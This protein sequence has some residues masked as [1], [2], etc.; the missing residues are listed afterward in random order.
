VTVT[1]PSGL[2]DTKTFTITV[3]D[4]TT[5]VAITNTVIDENDAGA[6]IGTLSAAID[7]INATHEYTY[8]LSGT[9]AGSF[10][11]VD[12][13][14]KLK[15]GIA[16]NYEVQNSYSVTVTATD[17]GGLTTEETFT[18]SV[19][20]LNDDPTLA[21]AI[22]DQSVDEDSALSFTV[23]ADTFNDEDGDTL[24]YT[25]TL[26]DSSALPSWLSFDASTQ[27]FSGTP[28]NADVGDI[29]IQVTASDGSTSVSD[30]FTLTVANT[31]DAPTLANA[32]ADQSVD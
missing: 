7:D 12:G 9:D 14:L 3:N 2:T 26:S 29:T 28:V 22:A 5:H 27:T 23:P 18:V 6:I 24:T 31:N 25:A 21:N 16:A 32:I 19:N 11:V 8:T 17:T 20:N 10:E 1:D 15:D 4:V 13:Q 30:T